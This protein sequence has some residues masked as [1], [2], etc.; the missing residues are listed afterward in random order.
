M[1]IGYLTPVQACT[2]LHDSI[3]TVLQKIYCRAL[4]DFLCVALMC[5]AINQRL[6]LSTQDP[7]AP[8]SDANLLLRRHKLL[9]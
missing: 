8:L 7:T 1:F 6:I 3:I 5:G 2:S 4:V 9:I